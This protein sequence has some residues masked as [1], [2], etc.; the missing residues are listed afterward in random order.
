MRRMESLL[1]KFK[2]LRVRLHRAV[3]DTNSRTK[4]DRERGMCNLYEIVPLMAET[5][6][7]VQAEQRHLESV[8]R[9]T[10]V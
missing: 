7:D 6:A 9:A 5:I 3:S 1:S 10:A 4:H 8:G 2:Q